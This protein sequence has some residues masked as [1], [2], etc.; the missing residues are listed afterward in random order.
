[1][2]KS[3]C[4]A[5]ILFAVVVAGCASAPPPGSIEALKKQEEYY[6]QNAVCANA[7]ARSTLINRASRGR[8]EVR[9]KSGWLIC[10]L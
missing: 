7:I 2:E 1:M 9:Y 3:R 4:V 5:A 6:R 10:R 8:I